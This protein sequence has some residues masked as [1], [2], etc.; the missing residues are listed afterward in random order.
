MGLRQTACGLETADETTIGHK[1]IGYENGRGRS[2]D[3]T[4]SNALSWRFLHS[5]LRR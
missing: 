2:D 3:V 1:T 4:V 5:T